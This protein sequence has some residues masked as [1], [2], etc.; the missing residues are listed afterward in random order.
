MAR[1]DLFGLRWQ[2]GSRDT[3]FERARDNF[4]PVITARKKQL[5][6]MPR[7]CSFSNATAYRYPYD[8]GQCHDAPGWLFLAVYSLPDTTTFP[9]FDGTANLNSN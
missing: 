2:G 5:R 3:A 4:Q 8:R 6:E 7:R 9:Y 1:P